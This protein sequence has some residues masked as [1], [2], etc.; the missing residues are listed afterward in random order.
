[1][2]SVRGKHRR[3]EE[4]I[5][6]SVFCT[7]AE[8][9]CFHD[10]GPR[11]HRQASGGIPVF[12]I[13]CQK[14]DHHTGKLGGWVGFQ[15]LPGGA[16]SEIRAAP[17]AGKPGVLASAP[18]DPLCGERGPAR[19]V[20]RATPKPRPAHGTARIP[21]A[22]TPATPRVGGAVA[23]E[24]QARTRPRL[25]PLQPREMGWAG[26]ARPAGGRGH[27][28]HHAVGALA[29][30]REVGVARSHVE[31]LPADHLRARARRCRR[32][33]V[34]CRAAAASAALGLTLCGRRSAHAAPPGG[35][36]PPPV[37]SPPLSRKEQGGR[38]SVKLE[39]PGHL[40]PT[41]CLTD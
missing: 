4:N 33:H 41:P 25:R 40:R 15:S 16:G 8:A 22:Q 5:I 19:E 1:M 10:Q 11:H 32:R 6:I 24:A 39:S 21:G 14:E 37:Q 23:W 7:Q 30:V 13:G 17:R 27:S 34:G 12:K 20:P 26:A 28:P 29:N 18:S 36:A 31:H 38:S 9:N 3:G 35:T 2:K